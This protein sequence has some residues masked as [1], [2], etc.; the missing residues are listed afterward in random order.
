MKHKKRAAIVA[1]AVVLLLIAGYIGTFFLDSTSS[2]NQKKDFT[3]YA[4]CYPVYAISRLIIGDVPGMRLSQ[5]TQPQL[6]GYTDYTLSDWDSAL[7]SNAD[8]FVQMGFGFEAFSGEPANDHTAVITLLSLMELK[9]VPEDCE[10]LNYT[11][12][13]GTEM[14]SSPWLYMSIDGMMEL[15]EVMC[16]NMA[17]LDQE[18]SEKYYEN[19]YAAQERL[20][21]LQERTESIDTLKG[22]KVAVAHDAL[23]YTASDLGA[24]IALY[25]R[26]S[27][28]QELDEAQTQECIDCMRQND[29]NILLI[30]EDA[31][32][33]MLSAFREAGITVICQQLMLDRTPAFTEQGYID[34][35][36]ENLDAIEGAIA[37]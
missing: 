25:I 17:Y 32:E 4:S 8:V 36:T 26:R 18:Y 31:D 10:I 20:L 5:L 22:K 28:S 23:I 24:E 30:E 3:I 14:G 11:Q 15:C 21:P 37:H 12:S 34:A 6:E 1:A 27:T 29:I 35:F 13:D 33:A 16:G 9:T 7:L 19:L 2:N